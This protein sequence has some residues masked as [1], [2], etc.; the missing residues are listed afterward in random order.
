LNSNLIIIAIYS[1][2]WKAK[3]LLHCMIINSP[4]R[5][6]LWCRIDISGTSRARSVEVVSCGGS[7][8]L[9]YSTH[10]LGSFQLEVLT[11]ASHVFRATYVP[12][13]VAETPT[14][15]VERVYLTAPCC[16][17]TLRTR[18]DSLDSFNPRPKYPAMSRSNISTIV[19]SIKASIRSS[20]DGTAVY[21]KYIRIPYNFADV[22]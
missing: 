18:N 19:C 10:A 20:S 5:N 13:Q 12:G 2:I 17:M 16:G 4:S 14:T 9:P 22:V 15:A 1:A 11:E 7:I 6:S 3:R 21:R 8:I